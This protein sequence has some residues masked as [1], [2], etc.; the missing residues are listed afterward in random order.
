MESIKLTMVQMDIQKGEFEV[1]CQTILRLLD[2]ATRSPDILMLPEMWSVGFDY[3]RMKKHAR[4]WPKAVHFL[5]HLAKTH[6]TVVMG[7]SVPEENGN[8]LFNTTFVIDP[9]GRMQDIYRKMHLLAENHPEGNVFDRGNR[10]PQF[11]TGDLSFG[12]ATCYDILF[13]EVTRGIALQGS[14]LTVVPAQYSNHLFDEWMTL[15]SARAMENQMMVAAVNRVGPDHFGHSC[16][17]GPDGRF[18]FRADGEEQ[19]VE[20]AFNPAMVAEHRSLRTHANQIHHAAL[21]Q[22]IYPQNFIGVGGFVERDGRI[23]MV[24]QN[25]GR[26]R[27]YWFLP[28]GH[29]KKGEAPEEGVAREVLEET[30]VKTQALELMA[31]RN[32]RRR[33]V[34]DSY[35][36]YRMKDLGG[37]PVPDGF[38]NTEAAFLTPHEILNEKPATQL[39]QAI[40]KKHLAGKTDALILQKDFPKHSKDYQLYL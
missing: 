38:E 5:S 17:I 18:L 32:L 29:L 16:L 8:R 28:G 30:R 31:L 1:N 20:T 35:Q 3:R 22:W 13:P 27:G 11:K 25:Y 33:G 36:V 24:R 40:V 2:K 10:I 39:A 34:V 37:D 23:L 14:I 26:L 6:N 9:D 19:L 7:G 21:N 4:C 12:V 15:L